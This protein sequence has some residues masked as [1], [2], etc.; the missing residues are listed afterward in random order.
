MEYVTIANYF[1]DTYKDIFGAKTTCQCLLFAFQKFNLRAFV[2]KNIFIC[3]L[4]LRFYRVHVVL[5]AL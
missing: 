1:S 2:L 3:V 4:Q 5:G